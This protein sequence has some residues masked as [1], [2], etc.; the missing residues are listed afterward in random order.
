MC[1][2]GEEPVQPPA[3]GA[4]EPSS[5]SSE[6]VTALLAVGVPGTGAA[7]GERNAIWRTSLALVVLKPL[8]RFG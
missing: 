2:F 6:T 3:D 5:T 1:H 7:I 4:R 8:G